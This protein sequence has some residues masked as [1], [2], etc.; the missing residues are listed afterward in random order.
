MKNSM[1]SVVNY[2]AAPGS[3]ELREVVIPE[4][5]DDDVLL[6]VEAVGV[7]G[8]DL[9]QFSGTHSWKVNYPV[10]LGHEFGGIIAEAGKNVRGFSEGDRVVSET[11][12]VIDP[13]S[14]FVRQGLYNLDPNRLGFGYGV[15]G[16]MARFVKVPARCLHAI[17]A[18]LAFEK[19]ALTEPCC[20]AYNAVSV[21]SRIKPGDSVV[22]IGPGP[23]G[24]LCAMMAKI[25]GAG[26]LIVVGTAADAGRL[27]VAKTIGANTVLG[28]NNED[29]R[30]WV[31]NFGDGYGVDLVIDA[32]GVSATL[33]LAIDIVRPAGQITKVGWGPQPINFSLDPLV[34]K[35]VTLQGSFS[36]NWPVWE[37]V[38]AML[39]TGQINLDPVLN[40]ISPLAEWHE[41]FEEMHKGN[42]VKAVLKP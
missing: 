7:C 14:P 28:A 34:Q 22:V 27:E 26:Q 36:H 38:L 13:A 37:K 6:A 32:A 29:V 24:L 17:P 18:G 42:V 2:A 30:E 9:H 20:V 39:G 16:A 25:A 35:N 19:A 31:K 3:V 5:G 33:K 12:A 8:S 15:N 11:A 4:I 10:V 23:I 41:A 40:R 1:Q 21:N